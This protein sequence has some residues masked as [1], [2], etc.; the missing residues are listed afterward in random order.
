MLFIIVPAKFVARFMPISFVVT[1]ANGDGPR[2][3]PEDDSADSP[4]AA[5]FSDK[6]E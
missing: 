2:A 5:L 1:M 3:L 6:Q 4:F